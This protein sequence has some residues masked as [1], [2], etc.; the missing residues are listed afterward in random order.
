MIP[1]HDKMRNINLENVGASTSHSPVGLHG[2]L[3]GWLY[4]IFCL[5]DYF[6]GT[7]FPIKGQRLIKKK[8]SH[9]ETF[10]HDNYTGAVF[11]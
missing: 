10:I 1:V 2:L 9:F 4:I 11:G 8:N 5:E 6:S 7:N 3:Q